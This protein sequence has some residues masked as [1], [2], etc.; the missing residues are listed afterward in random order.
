MTIYICKRCT[1]QYTH[2]GD[3]TRHISRRFPCKKITPGK[4]QFFECP[5]CDIIFKSNEAL[6]KH[7]GESHKLIKDL[8]KSIDNYEFKVDNK[9][10]INEDGT[11]NCNYCDKVF[12]K[13]SNLT[14]HMEQYCD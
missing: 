11:F 8:P 14:R 6:N 5:K 12:V 10:I 9:I 7:N 1:K 2:K 13:K 3:Y 4:T